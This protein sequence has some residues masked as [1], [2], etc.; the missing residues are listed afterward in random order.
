MVI[1]QIPLT[2]VVDDAVVV[3]PTTVSML[4][5]DQSLVFVWTHR[6]L[7]H[8]IAENLRLFTNVRIGQVVVAV[9]LE[10]EWAFSLTVGQTLEAVDTH[11]L[12][13]AVTKFSG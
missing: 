1:E 7:T 8:G 10:S 5:H 3:C 11:H 2:L 9:V 4:S 12:K 6:I 13:L